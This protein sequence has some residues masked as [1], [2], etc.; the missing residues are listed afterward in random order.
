MDAL[1]NSTDS[2]KDMPRAQEI[3]SSTQGR[4]LRLLNTS[5]GKVV[6]KNIVADRNSL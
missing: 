2:D 1:T 5:E 3:K 6:E 4:Y